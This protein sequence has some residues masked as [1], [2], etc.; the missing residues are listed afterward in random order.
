MCGWVNSGAKRLL[1]SIV[2]KYIPLLLWEVMAEGLWA[3]LWAKVGR[4]VE[5][6]G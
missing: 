3:G 1:I 4:K 5:S 2:K 6:D